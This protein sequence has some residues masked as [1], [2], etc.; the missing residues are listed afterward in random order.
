MSVSRLAL[1]AGLSATA[2]S[3]LGLPALAETSG[4]DLLKG[5]TIEE[6][7]TD[8]SYEVK[9]GFPE[10]L[11]NGIEGMELTG[12]AVPLTPGADVTDLILVSDMGLCPFCGSADHGASVQVSL[13]TPI[14]GLE[15][16][17]RITLKGNMKPVLDPE[18]WQA[19]IL[20][21]AEVV[22]G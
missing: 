16:G 7:V 22:G 6:I 1:T 13:N 18:T 2:V 4:W 8:S 10:R 15:E 21:N 20:E 5:I 12:Y 11:K 14:Q 9:K 3:T 17:A 19:A